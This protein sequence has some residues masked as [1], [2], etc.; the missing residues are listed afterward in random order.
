MEFIINPIT[1]DKIHLKSKLG[2]SLLKKFIKTF[3][4]K[5]KGGALQPILSSVEQVPAEDHPN[6]P[7]FNC[8]KEHTL[9]FMQL[10]DIVK[11]KLGFNLKSK[12][13]SSVNIEILDENIIGRRSEKYI[14]FYNN[15]SV[16]SFEKPLIPK[17][18]YRILDKS[19]KKI[20]RS[21]NYSIL[22]SH[23]YSGNIFANPYIN[24]EDTKFGDIHTPI[25][26]I[27]E[28]FRPPGD[29]PPF[30]YLFHGS[31]SSNL[32]YLRIG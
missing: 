21:Y 31:K 4:F 24:L 16:L 15:Y 17:P 3:L 22:L 26:N 19:K 29:E 10:S 14:Y 6:D 7:K 2:K 32:D 8:N 9:D 1:L 30:V 23:R 13:Y 27:I 28:P 5:Q 12:K 20:I 11:H 18:M 25:S